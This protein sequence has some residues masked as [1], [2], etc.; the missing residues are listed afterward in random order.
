ML[1]WLRRVVGEKKPGAWRWRPVMVGTLAVAL[2]LQPIATLAE[3]PAAGAEIEGSADSPVSERTEAEAAQEEAAAL[4]DE[5]LKQE[6]PEGETHHFPWITHP[7]RWNSD[8]RRLRAYLQGFAFDHLMF[9]VAYDIED[10]EI[11]DLYAGIRG[12]GPIGAVQ[13]GYMKEPFSLEHAMILRNLI[14]VEL[15]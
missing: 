6:K 3:D 9:R 1:E 11:E 14:G 8:F 13:A 7:D 5:L 10:E 12:L 15:A 2:L 4:E